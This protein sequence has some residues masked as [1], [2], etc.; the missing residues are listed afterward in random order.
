M[1]R[2]NK[3]IKEKKQRRMLK[4]TDQLL[5]DEFGFVERTPS[6][7]EIKEWLGNL[8]IDRDDADAWRSADFEVTY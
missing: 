1:N 2:T 6:R 7:E 8:L 4:E 3:D 5:C